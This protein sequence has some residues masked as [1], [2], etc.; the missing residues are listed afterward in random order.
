MAI[1]VFAILFVVLIV[2]IAIGSAVTAIVFFMSRRQILQH[3]GNP[4]LVSDP[5]NPYAPSQITTR[6]V[7]ARIGWGVAGVVFLLIGIALLA[8]LFWTRMRSA[9]PVPATPAPPTPVATPAPA[10]VPGQPN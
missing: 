1:G 3:G 8:A 2:G 10:G 6:V 7:G 5:S 9:A 4:P